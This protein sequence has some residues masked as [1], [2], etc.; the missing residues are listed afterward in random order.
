M[1]QDKKKCI[2]SPET[3]GFE[4]EYHRR[5]V[6]KYRENSQVVVWGQFVFAWEQTAEGVEVQQ[7][8][9]KTSREW[10]NEAL[11]LESNQLT[12][13]FCTDLTVSSYFN[14]A[15]AGE[16]KQAVFSVGHPE[17]TGTVFL[18]RCVALQSLKSNFSML[19]P[20]FLYKHAV[21]Y[22]FAKPGCSGS[23]GIPYYDAACNYWIIEE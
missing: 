14:S 6:I 17:L 10:E 7:V 5:G 15:S 20:Q 16:K 4:V 13:T 19:C 23:R 22:R 9:R 8:Q 12:F 11:V 2:F 3:S 18:E 1:S 21:H